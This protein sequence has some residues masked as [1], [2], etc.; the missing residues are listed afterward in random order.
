M[1]PL[2]DLLETSVESGTAP[3]AAALVARGDDVEV[4]RAGEVEME[5]IVRIASITKP[6]HAHCC[7]NGQR[8][9][10]NIQAGLRGPSYRVARRSIST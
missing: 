4:A 3:G 8:K 6:I 7:M 5:S 10:G 1:T 2:S 9:L